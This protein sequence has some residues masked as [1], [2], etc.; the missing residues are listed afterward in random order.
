MIPKKIL[1]CADFS[2]NSEPAC[3][4]AVDY[5]KNFGA[6]LLLL[7]A[8]NPQLLKYPSLED[9][10]LADTSLKDIEENANKSLE[11]IAQ[12]CRRELSEVKSYCRT[13]IPAQEI[14]NFA[15][16]E[17]V[18]LIVT[19]THG[20]TGFSHLLVGSTAEH[21]VRTAHRPVLTVWCCGPNKC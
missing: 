16:Q 1:F 12:L 19:G 11:K 7:H 18:D 6:E 10:P 3:E 17:S 5:A 15:S 2:K 4:L 8:I 13:G 14:V 20:W 21:V 9:L